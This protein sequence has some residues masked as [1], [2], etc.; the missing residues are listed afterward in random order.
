[1][2]GSGEVL[3][4]MHCSR[5]LRE[6]LQQIKFEINEIFAQSQ[7]KEFF[8]EEVELFPIENDSIDLFPML[9]QLIV[10]SLPF[11]PLCSEECKGICPRCGAD[12]N[13]GSCGCGEDAIDVRWEPLKKLKQL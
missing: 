13:E 8:P 11:K 7:M 12:L 3:A 2:K 1:M 5:C 4:I 10:L 9:R 6:F